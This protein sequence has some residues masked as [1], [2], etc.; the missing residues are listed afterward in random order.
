VS[1]EATL[2]PTNQFKEGDIVL[3]VPNHAHGNRSHPDCE[4]GVVTSIGRTGT[5]FVRFKGWTSQGCDADSLVM[6]GSVG[7][8]HV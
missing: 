2:S 6:Y 4:K 8:R 7:V 3:Y 1:D 5:V